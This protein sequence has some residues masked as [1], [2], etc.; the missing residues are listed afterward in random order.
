M[1]LGFVESSGNRITC[2]FWGGS[3]GLVLVTLR[4]PNDVMVPNRVMVP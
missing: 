1:F 3:A 4:F 2:D